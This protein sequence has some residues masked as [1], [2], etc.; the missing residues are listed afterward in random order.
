MCRSSFRATSAAI[1]HRDR[2]PQLADDL[3]I[4]LC[5][6]VPMIIDHHVVRGFQRSTRERF[7]P[8]L[9]TWTNFHT[10]EWSCFQASYEFW[11]VLKLLILVSATLEDLDFPVFS[12]FLSALLLLLFFFEH[13][14]ARIGHN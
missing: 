13:N 1:A 12:L 10:G 7:Y 2:V 5:S 6:T 3:T 11:I 9:P 4:T 8:S 14:W